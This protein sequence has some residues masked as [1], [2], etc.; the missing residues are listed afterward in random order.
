MAQTVRLHPQVRE[1]LRELPKRLKLDWGLAADQQMVVAALIHS[2]TDGQAAGMLMAYTKYL[3][4]VEPDE[5]EEGT[6]DE[7]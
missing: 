3:A 5:D 7:E 1:K 2:V 4:T 6:E